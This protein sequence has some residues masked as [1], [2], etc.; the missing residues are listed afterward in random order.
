MTTELSNRIEFYYEQTPVDM[1]RTR[2]AVLAFANAQPTKFIQLVHEQKF[3]ESSYLPVFFES[4]AADL[5]NWSD[6]F[7]LE[8]K[9]LIAA[10]EKVAR[11][12]NVLTHLDDFCFV[13]AASF[14]HR[15]EFVAIT[16]KMLTHQHAVFRFY[17]TSLLLDFM[18]DNDAMS[19]HNVKQL[20]HDS[21]WRVRA[22]VYMD[23]ADLGKLTAQDK[24]SWLDRLRL[25]FLDFSAIE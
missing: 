8:L 15:D 3:N 10:A 16:N 19:I 17:A 11:P 22:L 23:L 21:N 12:K 9:R 1:Q 5:A 13:N 20:L 18:N 2:A 25:K 4:L 7:L 24:F 6:F 14:K